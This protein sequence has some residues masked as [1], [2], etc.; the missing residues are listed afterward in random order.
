M[1]EWDHGAVR[2]GEQRLLLGAIVP[3]H[4]VTHSCTGNLA[5]RCER[6]LGQFDRWREPR[7]GGHSCLE[8]MAASAASISVRLVGPGLASCWAGTGSRGIRSDGGGV[9][10]SLQPVF[11]S[12]CSSFRRALQTFEEATAFVKGGSKPTKDVPN[13]RKLRL[14]GLFKQVSAAR[15]LSGSGTRPRAALPPSRHADEPLF[16]RPPRATTL[17]ASPACSPRTRRPTSGRPGRTTRVSSIRRLWTL[18][19]RASCCVMAC[20]QACGT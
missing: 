13:D 2:L 10:G 9:G 14:Y 17:P 16:R 3:P 19:P 5:A 8:A 7:H 15:E 6:R 1:L 20:K 4:A 11:H 18:A 12:A